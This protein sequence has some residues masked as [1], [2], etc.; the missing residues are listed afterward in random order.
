M[1]KKIL[2][3]N[4]GEITIRIIKACK[5]LNI[6]SVVVFADNDRDSFH[7]KYADEAYN[8]GSGQLKDTYLN[9]EKIIEI[10]KKSGSEAIHPGYGFLSEKSE[11]AKACEDNNISF[12]GPTSETMY[13]MG[14]K[15]RARAFMKEAG[16]PL[17][18]GTTGEVKTEAEVLDFAKKYGFPVALK[19]TAGGGGRGIK[20]IHSADEIKDSLESAMREGK[21][22]FGDDTV[23]VEKFLTRPRHI[24][25]QILGDKFG[26]VIHLGER[27]C[28]VQRRNQKLIEE[29]PSP[30][31]SE[32]FRQK[33][34][35]A[36]VKGAAFL[37]YQN[38]GTFEFLEQDGEFYFMEVNT[39]LQVEHP[40]TE[41]IYG[42]DLV[43]EQLSIAFGNKLNYSQNDI[44]IRGNAIEF[45]ITVED[46]KNNF[47]P[48][49][50]FIEDY[51]EPTG[52]G[53]RVDSIAYKGWNI[54]TEYDSLISKL[55]VWDESR[56]RAINKA[57]RALEEYIVKGV[58]TTIGFHQWSLTNEEF[59]KGDYS[60]NFI[61][62]NF[63]PEYLSDFEGF[64]EG[65][66]LPKEK[67]TIELEV[68]GKLFNVVVYKEK[69]QHAK[70]TR[71]TLK[72][73]K[74]NDSSNSNEVKAQMAGTV[75]KILVNKG[76]KIE[77][78]Q[79]LL[80]LE[81]MKMESDIHSPKDG[82]I[83]DVLVKQGESILSSQTMIVFE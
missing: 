29:S 75:V 44:K 3:A 49:A 36:A 52:L 6:K 71:P 47:R 25:V 38:A 8:I 42:V 62:K 76:D 54:P 69:E 23:Y 66:V 65:H 48:C 55:V 32:D 14:D 59:K 58:P 50:G 46:V 15:I 24:E 82:V 53:V 70:V 73:S 30:F 34:T 40:V 22:Y 80:I 18:P 68:N 11:F 79:N 74:K 28:S 5:E 31:L 43:K 60:T 41:M 45:R 83:K 4:R 9:I 27:N 78:G 13:A 21:N 81:A 77:K 20:V 1:F 10:A 51:Q 64:S 16:V 12:I 39:R 7:V 26:N 67:E 35:S 72:G 61:T 19:A 63:K 57:K 2:I 33:I 56:E 37:K 17:T